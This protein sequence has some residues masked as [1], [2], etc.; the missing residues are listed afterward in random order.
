MAQTAG[1]TYYAASSELVS[2]WPATSLDLANQ[3]ESR[4]AARIQNTVVDAKGDLI[5]ATA[6]DTVAR[7]AV[8]T[9]GQ[10]LTADS[11]TSTGLKWADATSGLNLITAQSFSSASSVSVNSCFTATYDDYRIVVAMSQSS[12]SNVNFRLRVAGSDNSSNQYLWAAPGHTSGNVNAPDFG[13]LVSAWQVFGGFSTGG[14]ATTAA[15]LDVYG[16]ARTFFTSAAGQLV[17]SAASNV[18][19]SQAFAGQMSVNTAYDGFTLSSTASM[20]GTVRVFGYRNS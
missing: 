3:L 9:N 18:I 14:N 6:A 19:T 17:K 10:V 4:F 2:S 5:A 11:S 20:T 13:S 1:G 15:S 16:P 8:G 7:L 12:P